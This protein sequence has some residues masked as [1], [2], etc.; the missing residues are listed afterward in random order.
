[1]AKSSSSSFDLLRSL[2]RSPLSNML[3]VC[4]QDAN[5]EKI[6]GVSKLKI[7][8]LN[9]DCF[10]FHPPQQSIKKLSLSQKDMATV[11]HHWSLLKKCMHASDCMTDSEPVKTAALFSTA[12]SCDN[13]H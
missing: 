3:L 6:K 5:E 2:S 11:K 10:I 12:E 8:E 1:M 4:A 13:Q 7:A 9:M